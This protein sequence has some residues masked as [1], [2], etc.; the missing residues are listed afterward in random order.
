MFSDQTCDGR[1]ER[2]LLIRAYPDKEPIWTLDAGGQRC[3]DASP[4]TDTNSS[5]EHCRSMSNASYVMSAEYGEKHNRRTKLELPSPNCLG[6]VG[7]KLFRKVTLD[8]ADHIVM[9]RLSTLA[10][11]P[12]SMVLHD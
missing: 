5:L 10:D 1:P 11:N 7:N 2:S 3:P 6:R 9:R 8:T 4:G 12:E